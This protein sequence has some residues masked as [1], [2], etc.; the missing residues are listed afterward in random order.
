ME[1]EVTTI[2][3]QRDSSRISVRNSVGRQVAVGA[4]VLFLH[5]CTRKGVARVRANT[6]CP[7][8]TSP[9]GVVGR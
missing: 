7:T 2:P 6:P 4:R 8:S 9:V 3:I 1:E 5:I